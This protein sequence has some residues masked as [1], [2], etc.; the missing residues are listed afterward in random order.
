MRPLADRGQQQ[1][2]F[3]PVTLLRISGEFRSPEH[4][5]LAR[6]Q[7]DEPLLAQDPRYDASSQV[8]FEIPM[9]LLISIGSNQTAMAG[10]QE[11]D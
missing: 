11:S 2:T 4:R 1:P 5:V 10:I 8:T 9:D 6:F 3:R 7:N